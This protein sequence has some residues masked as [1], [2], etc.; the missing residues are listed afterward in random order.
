VNLRKLNWPAW[1]GFLLTL[2]AF[3]SYFFVFVSFPVTRDF[4]WVN[5]LLFAFAAL[6]LLIGLRRAFAS[7]R[8]R[9]RLAKVAGLALVTVSV[10]VFGCFIFIT[11]INGRRLP[12][13]HSAPQVSQKAPDF[14]LADTTGKPVSL[15]ELLSSSINGK[16]TRGVLLIFYRGYW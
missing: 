2:V 4:P 13:S 7:D 5:L 11:L 14:A 12:A 10:A 1:A 8:P 3:L 16:P 9:P 15:S 6:L